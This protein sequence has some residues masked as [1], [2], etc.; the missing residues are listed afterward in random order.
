[1]LNRNFEPGFTV[2][3]AK[4]DVG[5]ALETAEE[6]NRPM[7]LAPLVHAMYTRASAEGR[8]TED[9]CA[10][11]KLYENAQG[12]L[13]DAADHVDEHYEGY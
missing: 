4:K 7:F 5:L 10:T 9:A 6:M 2:D 8:G 1:V 13:V 3:F 11:V 12:A